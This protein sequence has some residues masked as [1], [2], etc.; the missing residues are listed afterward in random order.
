MRPG[1]FGPKKLS[2]N[3][4]NRWFCEGA[5]VLTGRLLLGANLFRN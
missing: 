3:G 1:I 5:I 2:G 4:V